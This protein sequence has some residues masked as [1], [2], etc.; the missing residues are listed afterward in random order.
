MGAGTQLQEGSAQPVW[1][2]DSQ[3]FWLPSR[4]K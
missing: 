3:T 2:L 1:S 4:K